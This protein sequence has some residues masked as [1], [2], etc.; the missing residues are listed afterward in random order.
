MSAIMFPHQWPLWW[1]R[2]F[3]LT[4]PV[5]GP[6]FV[7]V[8]LLWGLGWVFL[9]SIIM[10]GLAICWILTPV[11]VPIFWLWDQVELLWW[12]GK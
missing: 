4:L 10:F 7:L 2:A 3:V 5:S 9:G 1:R 11:V 8:W 6:M 12:G